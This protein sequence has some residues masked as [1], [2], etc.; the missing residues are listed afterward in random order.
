MKRTAV[1][2]SFM[3]WFSLCHGQ[4]QSELYIHVD[5]LIRSELNFEQDTVLKPVSADR[6]IIRSQ[7][8]RGL[9]PS[10]STILIDNEPVIVFN[11]II[12]SKPT[13][14]SFNLKDTKRISVL[15]PDTNTT[16]TG[17]RRETLIR[18]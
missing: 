10:I 12:I 16:A 7:N 9:D 5:S 6:I 8:K 1:T 11:G 14:N 17:R 18:W 13:L 4:S 15:H 2:F 3:L